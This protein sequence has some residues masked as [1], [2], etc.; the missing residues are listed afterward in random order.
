M[1][2]N[3]LITCSIVMSSFNVTNS[4]FISNIIESFGNV[5]HYYTQ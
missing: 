5:R 4:N 3:I 1:K 2:V